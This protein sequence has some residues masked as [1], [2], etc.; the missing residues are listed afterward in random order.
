AIE[1][2]AVKNVCEDLEKYNCSVTYLPVY[3]N[4]IVRVEDIEA[5]ITDETILISVMA[6]NNEIG[7]MQPI[8]EIGRMARSL[9][10]KGR[11]IWF[12]T[13]AVQA[14]GKIPIDVEVIG[15]DLLSLSG[16]KIY[17]P[18]GVGA[19]YV[20]RGVRLHPQNIGGH[21]E[22]ERRGGT[23]SVPN[24]AG[25]GEACEIASFEMAGSS[26]ALR[27]MRDMFENLNQLMAPTLE[28][29]GIDIEVIL[30]DPDLM[31]EVD[32]N[33][34]EQVLI[35]LLVNAMEALKDRPDPRITLSAGV[36]QSNKV[37]L[38]IADNGT[39][40]ADELMDKIFIPFFSTKKS[41]SGIGLSLCKQ[42]M[43]LHKGTIQVHSVDGEG[44]AFTLTF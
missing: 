32:S 35:N 21:Q 42:I 30:K 22:R 16:H 12:H 43:M 27:N 26:N 10:V 14:A 6:A 19:L 29:K 25:F 33:L 36:L 13:D 9:R 4:G 38:K 2:S 17:A 37:M 5:A 15:C 44:T 23:E 3:E 24:I 8:E 1:H 28:Q 18:K 34:V 40:I 41:G 31:M 11:K 39:G 20:R 7:T